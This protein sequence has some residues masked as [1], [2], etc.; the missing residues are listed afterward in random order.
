MQR[1]QDATSVVIVGAGIGGLAAALRLAHAGAHVTVLDSHAAPGGK[2]RTIPSAAGPI[3]AGPTV[4]TMRSVFD[5]LF[6]AVGLRLDDHLTLCPLDIL[7]RHY[8][9]G[10][11]TLDLMADPNDTLARVAD[12]FGTTAADQVRRFSARAARLFDAFEGPMMKTAAPTFGGVAARVMQQP[13]LL[14]DMAP[15]RTLAGL[16]N[17]SFA[18]P[19]L[20]QLFARYATYVGGDPRHTP[21]LLS[22]IWAA[23]SRGV[24]TVAGGIHVLAQTLASLAQARGATFHYNTQAHAIETR[25]GRITGV[26]T[27]DG[28]LPADAV[29]FNG[30]PKALHD[31]LLGDAP[32]ATVQ[33]AQ[34]KP[35]S[36]SAHV[37]SFAAKPQGV[38]LAHHTLFFADDP[39]AE[40]A[41]IA[42][43]NTPTDAT[44]YLCAQDHGHRPAGA[45]Q[46]FEIIRNASPLPTQTEEPDQCAKTMFDRLKAFGLTLDAG[47]VT[48]TGPQEFARMF[49]GSDGALYGRS[50]Q[51]TM[52]AFQRPTARTRI[53]G[54]YL[55]G[56]GTHPGA[57]V[58]MAALSARHAAEAMIA[59]L[60]LT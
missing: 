29:L 6:H 37:A 3:D 55:C 44:L 34:V 19:R 2:M 41:A 23:E 46:R 47:P 32:K 22:L 39:A 42:R 57:G 30:D 31:G 56:G 52:A 4:L 18:D 15:H 17:R 26:R 16:A 25:D 11:T 7:A 27:D 33:S 43:R 21:A 51:G 54:L 36:L 45:L 60:S 28:T 40:F 9:P 1:A 10:G 14:R 24:W 38:P 58:P 12:V 48:I 35:R 53:N 49:P 13:V 8:W 50:P 20:A 5:D 59:D